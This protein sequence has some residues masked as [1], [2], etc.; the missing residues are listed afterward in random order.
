V[1]EG[2][3]NKDRNRDSFRQSRGGAS[4]LGDRRRDG[5]TDRQDS[6]VKI[7]TMQDLHDPFNSIGYFALH[8]STVITATSFFA[9][10][11][12]HSQPLI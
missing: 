3:Q 5:Q 4:A 8:L 12:V 11:E 7:E 1:I 2:E 10:D 6:A 9:F